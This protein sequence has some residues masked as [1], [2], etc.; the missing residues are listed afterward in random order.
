MYILCSNVILQKHDFGLTEKLSFCEQFQSGGI[1]KF[2]LLVK[3]ILICMFVLSDFQTFYFGKLIEHQS[4]KFLL[5]V[6]RTDVGW[7]KVVC[8]QFSFFALAN[9]NFYFDCLM[10]WLEQYKSHNAFM[11]LLR[12]SFFYSIG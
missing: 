12:K 11:L 5:E 7:K 9:K 3:A 4:K 8:V 10:T 2:S 6:Q 1:L